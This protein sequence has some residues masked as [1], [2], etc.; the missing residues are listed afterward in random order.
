MFMFIRNKQSILIPVFLMLFILTSCTSKLKSEEILTLEKVYATGLAQVKKNKYKEASKN[1]KK[2][3]FQYPGNRISSQAE[4]M[5]AYCS[6]CSG[7]YEDVINIVNR[8]IK[9][10]PRHNE[11]VYAYYL[12]AMA[13][14]QQVSSILLDQSKSKKAKEDFKKLIEY[15]PCT[16]YTVDI[17]LKINLLDN[18]LAGKEM[19]IGRY[20]LKKKNPIAAIKRFQTVI[21][22]YNKTSYSE[23]AL[24][25][26][27]EINTILGLKDEAMK[28]FSVL[29]YNHSGGEWIYNARNLLKQY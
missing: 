27:V 22:E 26:L 1:F 15:F 19:L 14:Y 29:E 20:Y 7:E 17:N 10:H 9:L 28:Y 3:V 24:Y 8:F 18:H 2:V 4:L 25:R 21:H 16:K 12:K 23:E 13:N 11:V 5:Q 6:Y